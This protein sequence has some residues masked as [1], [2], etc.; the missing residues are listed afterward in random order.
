MAATFPPALALSSIFCTRSWPFSM[1]AASFAVNSPDLTPWSMRFC[2]SA[3]R[4]SMPGVAAGSFGAKALG[5][6]GGVSFGAQFLGTAMGVVWAL[7]SGFVVYGVLKATLGL[8]L[9][10]EEEYDGADMTIHKISAAPDR[11]V[12]C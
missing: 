3:W 8:R 9:S 10:Q 6:L 12:S 4:L 7:L 2:C 1:R 11:E 5:G